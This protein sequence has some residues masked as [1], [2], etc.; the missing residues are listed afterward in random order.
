[1]PRRTN[2]IA[3][4]SVIVFLSLPPS[5]ASTPNLPWQELRPGAKVLFY[6]ADTDDGRVKFYVAKVDLQS[7]GIQAIVSPPKYIGARTSK[8]A[9]DIGAD[10]AISGGFWT[11]VTHKPLG[12]VVSAGKKWKETKDD[13]EYGFLAV[14]KQG[15]AWISPPEEIVKNVP[16]DVVSAIS[17]RPLIVKEG[18]IGRV[19]GCGYICM[20]HPRAA[21]GLDAEG[22]NMFLV[23]ADGRQES[24]VS[25][26]LR[27]LAR[28]LIDIGVWNA[29]NLD[30]GG[31][32]TLYI[33]EKGGVV[34]NPCEGKE[35]SVM[36]SLAIVW[37]ESQ[38]PV[39]RQT[40]L[41]VGNDSVARKLPI[42]EKVAFDDGYF[43]E[44]GKMGYPPR[45]I[46]VA[47]VGGIF[48]VV[49][50]LLTGLAVAAGSSRRR[51]KQK[52]PRQPSVKP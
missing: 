35:R 3:V 15:K 34:N 21:V 46:H 51:M 9:R 41:S 8:F 32:A 33:R 26:S 20:K 2:L 22:R 48:S 11:L 50:L 30:G 4:F 36:N 45:M 43:D 47:T 49:L 31:S 44:T 25:I 23:V 19:T 12:L 40:P 1:M 52:Q 14:T 13:G 39:A 17:G 29:L 5:F 10:L 27:T 38:L 42:K 37:G 18:N 24:S 7:E 16:T 6:Q 28:F